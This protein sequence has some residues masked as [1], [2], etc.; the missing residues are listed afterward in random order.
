MDGDGRSRLN[1]YDRADMLAGHRA[2]VT[3][4]QLMKEYNK[5]S[6]G[7]RA[8]LKLAEQEHNNSQ[9]ADYLARTEKQEG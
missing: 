6:S 9:Q 5:S 2:G 1:R 3:V 8:A 4:Q 7:I